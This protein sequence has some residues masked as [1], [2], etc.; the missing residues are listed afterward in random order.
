MDRIIYHLS[1]TRLLASGFFRPLKTFLEYLYE[2]DFPKAHNLLRFQGVYKTFKDAKMHI[3]DSKIIGYNIPEYG[4]L[5]MKRIHTIH[6]YDYPFLFW[7]SKL[8]H[9]GTRVFDLGGSVGVHYFG[10]EKYLQY[11]KNL[12]WTVCDLP[13]VTKIG[14]ELA[15]KYTKDNLHFS[16]SLEDADGSDILITA[17]TIQFIEGN[18][19]QNGLAKMAKKPKHILINKLPLADGEQFVTLQ[20]AE[21][22]IVPS[23]IFNREQFIESFKLL[24]YIVADEWDDLSRS[25]IIPFYPKKSLQAYSGIYLRLLDAHSS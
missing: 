14:Q 5:Y 9:E 25:C 16:N 15:L 22:S 23:Y 2:R 6:Q 3:P 1:N 19:L 13:E 8:I 12:T 18:F 21:H 4:L 11:P 20:N 17:G 10:Y 24:D 7:L